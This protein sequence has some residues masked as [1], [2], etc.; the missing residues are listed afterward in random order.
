MRKSTL[1]KVAVASAV[2]VGAGS[3]FVTW[4][5]CRKSS[6]SKT[7][8]VAAPVDGGFIDQPKV[9]F[10]PSENNEKFMLGTS[11]N[12]WPALTAAPS[13]NVQAGYAA[14]PDYEIPD[15]LANPPPYLQPF[16]M[17]RL[18]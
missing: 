6:A 11:L 12:P 13:A 9:L 17:P 1:A 7:E 18:N 14:R 10:C 5:F 8:H 3:A 16:S 4:I 15:D 2:L